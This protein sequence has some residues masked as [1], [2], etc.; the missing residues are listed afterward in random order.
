ML[1]QL[2]PAIVLSRFEAIAEASSDLVRTDLPQSMV[3]VLGD[4]AAKGRELPV[5]RLELVPPTID[6]IDPDYA[7]VRQLIDELVTPPPDS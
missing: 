3:G 6:N 5:R 1:M 4:L 2:D 7:L